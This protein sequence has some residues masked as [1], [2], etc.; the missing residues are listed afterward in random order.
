MLQSLREIREKTEGFFVAK[1]VPNAKLDAD[2]LIAKA[3]KLKR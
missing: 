2:L 3:L 1:G